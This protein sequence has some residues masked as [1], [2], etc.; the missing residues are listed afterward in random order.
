MRGTRAQSGGGGSSWQASAESGCM[1]AK[2]W[3]RP[4][5]RRSSQTSA[6]LP[7]NP[8]MPY[9]PSHPTSGTCPSMLCVLSKAV[10]PMG[11]G[12]ESASASQRD[13][14]QGAQGGPPL[15]TYGISAF[16]G[17]GF[18]PPT[19]AHWLSSP[20][21]SLSVSLPPLMSSA[22]CSRSLLT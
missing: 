19:P 1:L 21:E 5:V 17:Q 22:T 7:E 10:L 6:I 12:L 3:S 13:D 20:L 11:P 18:V 14:G 8:V 15:S 2:T 16:G 4:R 9:S